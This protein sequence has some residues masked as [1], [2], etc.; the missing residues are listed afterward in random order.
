M[1]QYRDQSG[2]NGVTAE[3]VTTVSV[4]LQSFPRTDG[5]TVDS[6][7]SLRQSFI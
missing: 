5:S 6:T 3:S 7:V 1:G 4:V 2:V